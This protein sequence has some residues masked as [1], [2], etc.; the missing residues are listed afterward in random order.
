MGV[1]PSGDES[2]LPGD[3]VSERPCKRW[4]FECFPTLQTRFCSYYG[5]EHH[6]QC[7]ILQAEVQKNR[8]QIGSPWKANRKEQI[9]SSFSGL[10]ASL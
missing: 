10:S 3:R 9:P 2:C 5:R 6:C 4:F 8:K 7:E 1:E